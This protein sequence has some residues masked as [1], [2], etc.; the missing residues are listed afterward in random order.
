MSGFPVLSS[1]V[2]KAAQLQ[3]F[4]YILGMVIIIYNGS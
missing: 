1:E 4:G 2:L 3:E